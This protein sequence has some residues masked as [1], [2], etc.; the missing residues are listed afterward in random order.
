M[1]NKDDAKEN[2]NQLRLELRQ[3]E[4]IGKQDRLIVER[5]T[6]AFCSWNFASEVEHPGEEQAVIL[7]GKQQS[8]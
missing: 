6:A 2:N 7:R 5:C 8:T 3:R 1:I 4:Q